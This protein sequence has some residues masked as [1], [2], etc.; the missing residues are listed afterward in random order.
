MPAPS[1]PDL[2]VKGVRRGG[3][4]SATVGPGELRTEIGHVD[5]GIRI[6]GVDAD[7]HIGLSDVVASREWPAV[8]DHTWAATFCDQ[9]VHQ[10]ELVQPLLVL[11]WHCK[12][13]PAHAQ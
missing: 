3:A 5:L 6:E 4:D 10:A 2:A 8:D 1:L 7:V 9:F 13:A 12:L 11:G